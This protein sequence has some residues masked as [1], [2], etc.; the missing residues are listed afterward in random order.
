MC[1][2]LQLLLLLPLLATCLMLPNA[3]AQQLQQL[4]QHQQQQQRLRLPQGYNMRLG[5]VPTRFVGKGA[6]TLAAKWQRPQ[7]QQQP[8]QQQLQLQLQQQQQ[9]KKLH[10]QQ[11]Q[12]LQQRMQ[13]YQWA[14]MGGKKF[15]RS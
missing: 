14:T 7:Q 12:Q 2:K 15:N 10:Q 5:S 4:Q 3:E 13:L 6:Y 1:N 9:L 8:Q 11:Q